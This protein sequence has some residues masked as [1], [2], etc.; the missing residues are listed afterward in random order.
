M[1]ASISEGFPTIGASGRP[2]ICVSLLPPDLES[3][4]QGGLDLGSLTRRM[5]DRLL[6]KPAQPEW[7]G[8]ES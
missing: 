2:E 6:A 7:T 1:P 8:D 3:T 4:G 5:S